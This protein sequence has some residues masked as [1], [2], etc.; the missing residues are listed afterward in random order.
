MKVFIFGLDGASLDLLLPWIDA[1]HLPGFA[2]LISEG[3]YGTLESVPNQ[4]SAAAWTS[5]QTGKNPGKHG[6][7]EFYD[8]IPNTYDIRFVNART[9]EGSS[10]FRIASD[11]GK[12][13][14][15]INVPMSYPAEEINGTFLAGLDAPGVNSRGFS[16]PP[17]LIREVEE[18]VGSYVI[19]PGMTGC[20]VNGEVDKAADL[21]FEEIECKKRTS[22]Y[23]MKKAPW[24]LFVTI[25]RSTDA[26]HHCFW[27]YH[28][29]THPQ[30]DPVEAER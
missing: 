8:R 30:H 27:K 25:F 19:E 2:R 6:I 7:L 1:G 3:S 26:V 4:R 24:D 10:F 18:A 14:S 20:I 23:L 15:V 29:P 22:R 13:M 11:A 16:Y 28:D 21:L 9:R 5:F 12:R 17:A